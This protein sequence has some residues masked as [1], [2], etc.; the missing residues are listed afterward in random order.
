MKQVE[1]AALC[2]CSYHMFEDRPY[3]D[4]LCMMCAD[5]KIPSANTVSCDV[6]DIY[7][8]VKKYVAKL[9]QIWYLSFLCNDSFSLSWHLECTD[10][11]GWLGSTPEVVSTWASSHLG[12]QRKNP[13]LDL[14]HD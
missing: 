1:W 9:L 8:I 2:H 14:G 13:G 10:C 12:H 7:N 5:V 4:I 6:K 11:T 3:H